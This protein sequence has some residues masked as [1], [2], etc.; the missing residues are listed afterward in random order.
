MNNVMTINGYQAVI[1]YDP[2]IQMFRGEFLGL[3]GGADFYARDVEGLQREGEISLKVFLEACA[4]D[5][6]DPRKTF[7]GKFVLRID[8]GDPSGGGHRGGG[9]RNEPEPMGG[10]GHPGGN[11]GLML[12]PPTPSWPRESQEHRNETHKN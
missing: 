1:N 3:N 8:P 9:A 5:G 4:E 12:I 6:V 2:E 11:K 10:G 7:S